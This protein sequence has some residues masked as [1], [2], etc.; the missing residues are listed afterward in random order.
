MPKYDYQCLECDKIFE[1]EQKMVDDPLEECLCE[2]EKFFVNRIPSKPLLVIND[3]GSM[4][5]RKLYKEL[6][7]D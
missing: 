1:V 7:I 4:P 6:D 3:A 5:D 2:N